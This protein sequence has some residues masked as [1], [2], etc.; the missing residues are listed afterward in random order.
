MAKDDRDE[1]V[2]G[3]AIAAKILNRMKTGNKERLVQRI[4]AAQPEVFK[5][6]VE[7]LYNFED[8]ATL[9]PQSLQVLIKEIEHRDLVVS[10]KTASEAVKKAFFENM[11][12][13]K[14]QVV[15]EDY[16]SLPPTRLSEVEEAQRRIMKTL[17][18]LRT[19]GK[20]KGQAKHD[21]WV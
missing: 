21:V 7:N 18:D 5:K 12:P 16:A 9:T 4:Q 6:I 10:L 20:I 3:P 2:D 15:Q 13:R 14:L 11:S 17:E 8:I 1:A 19:S